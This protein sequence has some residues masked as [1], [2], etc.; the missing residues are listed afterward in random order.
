MFS[1]KDYDFGMA[2]QYVGDCFIKFSDIP[3]IASGSGQIKQLNLTLTRLN[4]N[5]FGEVFYW[6]SFKNYVT[7]EKGGVHGFCYDVLHEKTVE[8]PLQEGV[9]K[10]KIIR[11]V[12]FEWPLV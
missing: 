2:N 11:D 9:Q 1:V 3:D 6:G 5:C 4:S 7:L 10:S 8:I 12:I